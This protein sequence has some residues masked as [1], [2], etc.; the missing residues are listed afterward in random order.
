[1]RINI[2][3]TH[4]FHLLDLAREMSRQGHDVAFYSFVPEKRCASFGLP[5]RCCHSFTW[6]IV[7]FLVLDRLFPNSHRIIKYWNL[8]MDYYMSLFMRPCDVYIA[9][10]S[11][12]LKSLE[13]AKAKYGAKVILE[14]GSKH[15][16]EQLKMFGK[17]ETYSKY[18]LNRELSQYAIADYISI[19]TDH[20]RESFV[21]NGIDDRKL[22]VNPYGVSLSQFH[23]TTLSGDYDLIYV[24][25]WRTE[26]GSNYLVE[27][28][29]KYGYRLIHVGAIVNMAF[30]EDELFTHIDAV[31]QK[32]LVKYYSKARVFVI[33]SLSEGLAMVQAQAI[34]CGL[35]VVCSKNS[36]GR[37][38]KDYVK[39]PEYIIE[40][41]D[42]SIETLHACIEQALLLASMQKGERN[43]AG[44]ISGNLSW[45]AYGKRYCKFLDSMKNENKCDKE[46]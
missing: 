14:W 22:F 24:G 34:A 16:V 37:D 45:E 44:N 33:P 25:G 15:I 46:K 20:V 36:G 41:K 30:P 12:Y 31:D 40:M 2:A 11:V 39:S 38:L 43:Y 4:R 5:K 23:P 6:F 42:Y 9:L 27:V 19:S 28:C 7:P 8:A 32:E 21:K 10:G 17:L 26:K 13:S 35:P 3:S 29:R 1:M 18:C